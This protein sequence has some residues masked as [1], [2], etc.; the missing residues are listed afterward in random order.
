MADKI[1]VMEGGSVSAQGSFDELQQRGINFQELAL[2]AP[3]AT[4]EEGGAAKPKPEAE[5]RPPPLPTSVGAP[6]RDED[7]DQGDGADQRDGE[8]ASHQQGEAAENGE[9]SALLN[10]QDERR[11]KGKGQGRLVMDEH[12]SRGQVKRLVYMRYLLAWGPLC[13]LPG[14]FTLFVHAERVLQV[15]QNFWLSVWSQATSTSADAQ[16]SYYMAVY[17]GLGAASLV[18]ALARTIILTYGANNA[19]RQL[20]HRL[21]HTIL[22]LPMS[23]F[24]T[25]PTGRLLNRFTKDTEAVDV[26]LSGSISSFAMC[27]TMVWMSLVVVIIVTPV[28]ILG[29]IPIGFIYLRLQKVF[30]ST[31]RELK[32]LD[33]IAFSPIFSHF[34]ETLSGL[35]T[36]RAFRCQDMFNTK[37]HNLLDACNR[38][39][40]PI[41]VVNR[42]LSVRLEL[43][44]IA[45]SFGTAIFVAVVLPT[46]GGLAGLALTSALNL[47]G[48]MTWL[49][50]QSTELE[51]NMNSVE[52]LMEYDTVE[53]EAAAVVEDA[54][55]P[56]N[57]PTRGR[58]VVRQLEVRYRSDLP[59]VLKGISFDVRE[60]EKIGIAGRT[61]CGKSTLMMTMFRIVEPCGGSLEIDGVDVL[62]IGLRDLRSRLALVPQD[63]VIFSGTVRSNLDPF[64]EHADNEIWEALSKVSMDEVVRG[65]SGGLFSPIEEGGQNL[66]VG[67]RQLLGMARALVRSARILILDEATSNVDTSTDLLIQKTIREAFAHCSVLTIAHRLHT[68]MKADR[69]MV[70]DDGNISEFAAPAE[71]LENPDGMF[72]K[73]VEEASKQQGGNMKA[74]ASEAQM[75]EMIRAEAERVRRLSL[76]R[77]APGS[78]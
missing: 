17:F 33:S 22:R 47:T 72:S 29:V 12:R 64:D 57:W 20:H 63:P 46:N 75:A 69:I 35:T 11:K 61:G 53:P 27:F 43:I 51:V 60:A 19:A 54:R 32:R 16:N 65:M 18:F 25:Q 67:Q 44:G 70:L 78:N 30:I 36:V 31:S 62:R 23:F 73:L 6:Q 34:S 48:L 56:G 49:V 71:L 9:R 42:W 4:E 45:I 10:G 37:N 68:I 3:K 26:Q 13:I 24:D 74:S 39:W 15:L 77:K 76:E 52:R 41:Q 38:C 2:A 7:E 59:P 66:S 58:I 21:L 40:W 5:A 8:G 1:I 28:F 50:R 55:P 14:L